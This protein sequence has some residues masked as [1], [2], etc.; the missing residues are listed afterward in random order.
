MLPYLYSKG[1]ISEDDKQQIQR[2]ERSESTGR[3]AL[4]LLDLLPNRNEQWF[5]HFIASLIE[6][7]Q[8]DLATLTM[9]KAAEVHP[10]LPGDTS[11][12]S[13]Q[14]NKILPNKS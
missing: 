2:T 7:G 3:A 4:E 14:P 6:S 12:L 1:V 13:L 9:Q 8:D 5:R 10:E 11:F